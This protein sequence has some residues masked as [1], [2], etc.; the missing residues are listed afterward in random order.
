MI[1]RVLW[2]LLGVGAAM[3]QGAGARAACDTFSD[4]KAGDPRLQSLKGAVA[5]KGIG[6][7]S[8]ALVTFKGRRASERALVLSAAHC[9]ERGK[10]EIPLATRSMP[11]P[12]AGE[13]LYRVGERRT[14]TLDAGNIEAPRTCIEIDQIVYGTMT[15][16][17]ILLL[18]S[19]E[20]YDQIRARTGVTPFLVSGDTA[21]ADGLAVR[22]PSGFFQGQT[23][24]EVE[25]T[26]ERLKE[27]RWSWGPVL[28]LTPG[29]EVPHGL[30]GAPIIRKDTSE[31]IGI[32]GTAND[33]TAEP[34][35]LN[36]VCE[37]GSGG[38]VRR[39][40]P[41]QGYGH[42]VHKLYGCLDAARSLDLSTPG[43]ALPKP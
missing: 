36:N 14:L 42:F 24:C 30:S 4:I 32:L 41:E 23:E 15:E 22:L 12:D 18:Q 29:C 1:E 43:C 11:L 13:V 33:G 21:F 17:D 26:V 7:C 10:A 25:A 34:C 9:S 2:L 27:D 31:V 8:A 28:R 40:K 20:T 3:A 39:A 37:I 35:A 16:A 38:E 5:M 19:T 6:V